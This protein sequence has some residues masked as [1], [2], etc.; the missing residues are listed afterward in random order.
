LFTR[1]KER[2]KNLQQQELRKNAEE[3]KT[4]QKY[5]FEVLERKKRKRKFRRSNDH[6]KYLIKMKEK[7]KQ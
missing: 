6:R 3:G 7:R 5:T 1:E 4:K 2:E